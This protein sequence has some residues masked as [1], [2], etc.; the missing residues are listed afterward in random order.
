[1]IKLMGFKPSQSG[2]IGAAGLVLQPSLFCVQ[3]LVVEH[4]RLRCW[5]S[6]LPQFEKVTIAFSHSTVPYKQ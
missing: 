2:K 4:L 3:R 1:M 6:L 5:I